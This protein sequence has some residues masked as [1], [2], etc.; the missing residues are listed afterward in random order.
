[1]IA[2]SLD[3]LDDDQHLAVAGDGAASP[4]AAESFLNTLDDDQHLAVAGDGAA[5]PVA[6]DVEDCTRDGDRI[7]ARVRHPPEGDDFVHPEVAGDVV[8]SDSA[9]LEDS[10]T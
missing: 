4:V 1:M 8:M 6:E 10:A 3:T 2:E 9:T 5:A 7:L